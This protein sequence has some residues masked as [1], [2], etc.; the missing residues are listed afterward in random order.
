MV[1]AFAVAFL[2]SPPLPVSEEKVACAQDFRIRPAL[3]FPWNCDS[4]IFAGLAA[5][6]ESL[7]EPR[8]PGKVWQSRPLFI[9]AAAL[10]RAWFVTAFDLFRVRPAIGTI[11]L[12]GWLDYVLIDL[13]LLTTALA[14]FWRVL[15][16]IA[17]SPAALAAASSFL[18]A[19]RVVKAYF[20]TPHTQ[21]FNVCVPVLAIALTVRALES[22]P[23]SPAREIGTLL[24]IGIGSL[25]YG[26]FLTIGV[27]VAIAGV[28][29]RRPRPGIGRAA[30]AVG[31]R[32]AIVL[33]PPA[34]WAVFIRWKTGA[35]YSREV[36]E[37]HE[38]VWP[39]K[40]L[41]RGGVPALV[42]KASEF[43]D[44]FVQAT[45]PE[46]AFPA[47]LLTLLAIVALLRRFDVRGFAPAS[48]T[49]VEASV[50]VLAVNGVFYAGLGFYAG[51][52]S[53]NFYPEM[54]VVT[55]VLAAEMSRA[56]IL[57]KAA[58]ERA[59][60]VLAAANFLYWWARAGPYS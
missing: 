52:L 51:R 8:G 22:A 32:A 7:L 34:V 10:A 16:R 27:A 17:L 6:P 41:A 11:A 59:A 47:A 38:F 46:L 36:D 35:F 2:S 37:Y 56:G 53:W 58:V 50:I 18:V 55:L 3:G 20:W 40:E 29:R 57:R 28:V 1:L 25:A 31:G 24:A 26:S 5:Q 30:L 12:A 21:I 49:L 14:V 60:I 33:L 48:R 42:R 54:I 4:V 23:R 13:F 9:A 19:N 15:E 45:L 39:I 43:H 44:K